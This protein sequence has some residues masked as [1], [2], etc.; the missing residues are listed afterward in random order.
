MEI[1]CKI[2]LTPFPPPRNPGTVGTEIG[3]TVE[4][5]L[6]VTRVDITADVVKQAAGMALRKEP[7]VNIFADNRE[8][9][10][11]ET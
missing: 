11:P 1:G 7:G 2:T 10:V 4:F 9:C 5:S 8:L 6:P 3:T